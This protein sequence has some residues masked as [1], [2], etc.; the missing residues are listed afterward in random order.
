M[1]SKFPFGL[2]FEEIPQA[3]AD[4]SL[5]PQYNE[6]EAISYVNDASGTPVPFVTYAAM[7]MGVTTTNTSTKAD[8]DPTDTDWIDDRSP[9][10][11]GTRTVTEAREVTDSD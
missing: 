8:A 10:G 1:D 7:M 6:E 11:V 3:A 5:Q 4:V 9:K 2:L